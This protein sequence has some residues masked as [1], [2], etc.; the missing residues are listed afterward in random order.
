MTGLTC[1]KHLG[2][3]FAALLAGV[4]LWVLAIMA[5]FRLDWSMLAQLDRV[6]APAVTTYTVGLYLWLM[7]LVFLLKKPFGLRYGGAFDGRRLAMGLGLGLGGVVLLT[8]IEVGLGLVRFVPP[9][10][11]RP[12]VL[13]GA[14][15]AAIA[16]GLS[17]ELVFRGLVL[18]TL[19]QDLRPWGA[20]ALSGLIFAALHFLRPVSAADLLPFAG[21]LV[22]GLALGYAAWKSGS[23][24]LSVGIHA[25]WVYFIA[26]TGQL[27]LLEVSEH[28]QLWAGT[29]GPSSGLLGIVLLAGM[30]PWL[31]RHA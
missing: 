20:V 15:V 19:L 23:L 25:G 27:G 1:A 21:L 7:A 26:V 24:W 13:A 10:A 18:R 29:N 3:F 9:A 4:L 17:E 31:R 28:G 8:A 5:F 22:A 14:A 2:I 11:W 12:E 6:P 30:F 16:F